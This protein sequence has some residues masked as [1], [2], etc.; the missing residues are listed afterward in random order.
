MLYTAEAFP[1]MKWIA[2]HVAGSEGSNRELI[3]LNTGAGVDKICHWKSRRI[4][5][6]M[7][8]VTDFMIA[9]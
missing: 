4:E 3:E 2:R 6:R 7:H 5:T 9:E 8:K 1:N